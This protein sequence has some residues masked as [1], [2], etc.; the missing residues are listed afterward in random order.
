MIDQFAPFQEVLSLWNESRVINNGVTVNKETPSVGYV[1]ICGMVYSDRAVTLTIK[2]GVSDRTGS[3]VYRQ[4]KS[5][6]IGAGST[7]IVND[8]KIYGKFVQAEISNTS[9]LA[10]NM[11]IFLGLRGY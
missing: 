2:Q 11:E 10:A 3:L 6:A 1:Y 5:F 8:E 7:A 9:G 4:T